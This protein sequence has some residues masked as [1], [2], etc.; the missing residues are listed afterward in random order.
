MEYLNLSPQ[1]P[2]HYPAET[3]RLGGFTNFLRADKLANYTSDAHARSEIL[4]RCLNANFIN[5]QR[6]MSVVALRK[7]ESGDVAAEHR[8][9]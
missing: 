8:Q 7:S 5:M 6:T 3:L 4:Q 2:C 1:L 9:N